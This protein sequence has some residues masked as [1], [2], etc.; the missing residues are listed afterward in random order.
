MAAATDT[1]SAT[2]LSEIFR[3]DPDLMYRKFRLVPLH[4]YDPKDKDNEVF[5]SPTVLLA[6]LELREGGFKD[7]GAKEVLGLLAKDILKSKDYSLF[8]VPEITY[9]HMGYAKRS[10]NKKHNM[11]ITETEAKAWMEFFDLAEWKARMPSNST[12]DDSMSGSITP[13]PMEVEVDP[14]DFTFPTPEDTQALE[15]EGED[16][17]D[18]VDPSESGLKFRGVKSRYL[19]FFSILLIFYKKKLQETSANEG[20]IGGNKISDLLLFWILPYL[21]NFTQ[22][23][24]NIINE[25]HKV[26]SRTK[27]VPKFSVPTV[28]RSAMDIIQ[29]AFQSCKVPRQLQQ[30]LL[31]KYR[32]YY[33]TD[34]LEHKYNLPELVSRDNEPIILVPLHYQVTKMPVEMEDLGKKWR[35]IGNFSLVKEFVD[36]FIENRAI[37][38][39]FLYSIRDVAKKEEYMYAVDYGILLP[40][41][42]TFNELLHEIEEN[43][44]DIFRCMKCTPKQ[45]RGLATPRVGLVKSADK[46]VPVSFSYFQGEYFLILLLLWLRYFH[47]SFTL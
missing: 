35:E 26:E 44:P 18:L 38:Q 3:V 47:G 31:E 10:A 29:D 2:T 24:V 17:E 23:Q 13:S 43:H 11:A 15:F 36:K 20:N 41:E 32:R 6:D 46:I 4:R 40:D 8:Q 42:D 39:D 22:Q 25:H 19:L 33:G 30:T 37:Q 7:R 27:N 28:Q 45:G 12:V 21:L 5:L 9:F 34:Q 1:T 14:A 16:T